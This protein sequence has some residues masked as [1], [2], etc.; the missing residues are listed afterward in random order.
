MRQALTAVPA[1]YAADMQNTQVN[2]D[3]PLATAR[4]WT[5]C[6]ISRG[7]FYKLLASGRIGPMPVRLG[8]RRPVYLISDLESWLQAGA[9]DRATWQRLRAAAR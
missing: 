4:P 1:V 6:G 9:P 8:T 5:A 3:Q 2:A 7:Q